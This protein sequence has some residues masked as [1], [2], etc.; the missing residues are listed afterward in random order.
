M[1][2]SYNPCTQEAEP[3]GSQVQGYSRLHSETPV[4]KACSS[5]TAMEEEQYNMQ[6]FHAIVSAS[7]HSFTVWFMF[8]SLRHSLAV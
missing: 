4:L 3:G 6:C 1:E 2:H 8:A 5:S 7:V